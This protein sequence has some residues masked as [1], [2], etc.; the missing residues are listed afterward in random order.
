LRQ[1][2]HLIALRQIAHL[3]AAD[4]PSNCGTAFVSVFT[5]GKILE[6][7]E[8]NLFLAQTLQCPQNRGN[9][10]LWFFDE[11]RIDSEQFTP[12]LESIL[13]NSRRLQNQPPHRN[14]I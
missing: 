4:R 7:I 14:P 6:A 11:F 2:A 10:K 3:I 8:L 12:V 1:I 13:N 9:G 5:R